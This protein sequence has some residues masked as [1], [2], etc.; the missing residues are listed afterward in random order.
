[1]FGV[2][3]I[4]LSFRDSDLFLHVLR[5]TYTAILSFVER[6]MSDS[7]DEPRRVPVPVHVFSKNPGSISNKIERE[8]AGQNGLKEVQVG[9]VSNA[10]VA[11]VVYVN[12]GRVASGSLMKSSFIPWSFFIS[13]W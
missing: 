10:G 9:S 5:S 13:Y 7:L 8:R 2:R 11:L 6:M 1:M 4:F 3:C 12:V